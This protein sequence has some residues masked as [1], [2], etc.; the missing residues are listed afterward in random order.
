MGDEGRVLA[1]EPSPDNCAWLRRSVDLN[2]YRSIELFE[3]ALSDTRGEAKLYLGDRI[4][5]HSLLPRPIDQQTITVPVDTLDSVLEATGDPHVD[6]VKIDV[7]G[8]E[9]KVLQ[10]G[11]KTLGRNAPMMLMIDIHPGRIDPREVC[12]LLSDYGF[13]LRSPTD[14]DAELEPGPD[15]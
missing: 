2:G 8:A 11:P 4:G 9:L 3:I 10:G 7:E 6:V 14:P 5:R 1:F 13:S 12:S 15:L